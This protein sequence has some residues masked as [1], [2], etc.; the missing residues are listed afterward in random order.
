[1]QLKLRN[2]YLPYVVAVHLESKTR[3]KPLGK[4]YEDWR[5]EYKYMKS[6]WGKILYKDPYYSPFLTDKEED[7]SISIKEKNLIIR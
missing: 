1:M 3:G 5:K 4:T 2:L 7:W 6:K